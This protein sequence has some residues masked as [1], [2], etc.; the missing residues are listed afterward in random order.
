MRSTLAP[1]LVFSLLSWYDAGKR[2]F[3][4][5]DHPD[6][7]AVLVSEFMLQQT[8]VQAVIPY[9]DRWMSTYPT[10]KDLAAAE[11]DE[12]LLQ[13]EGL[14]YYSRA[15]NLHA[16]AGE[17]IASYGGKVPGTPVDLKKLPGIGEYTAAAVASIA[18]G[19]RAPALDANNLR[20][21]SRLLTSSD[22]KR[23]DKVFAR[24]IPADRPGDFNQA[25][26]DLGS[27]VCTPKNPDCP[28]CPLADWCR[29]YRTGTVSEY[30]QKKARP[31]TTHIEAAI[32]II[33]RDGMVLVQRRA[34]TGLM[35]GL[36]EFPGGKI[37]KAIRGGEGAHGSVGEKAR[38]GETGKR[39]HGEI[40]GVGVSECR[41]IGEKSSKLK[42]ETPEEAVLHEVL[43]ET[44]LT[45]QVC[46]K[47]GVFNHA[48]TRFRVKLHVFICKRKAGT[49]HNPTAKWVTLGELEGLAMPSVNRRIVKRLEER[50]KADF[51]D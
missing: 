23:I 28:V 46:E 48:Y 44:G 18:F 42:A 29:A 16:A 13:W 33:V 7:Y 1:D 31:D 51:V 4:W 17:I 12:V 25:L 50:L 49:V 19:V 26:M 20:V 40:T 32:G 3:P 36:W 8:T 38:R 41:R 39:G 24:V 45:V 2:E 30:P 43:E 22:K 6:P 9:F 21:W 47:L 5:R 34:D 37:R 35:A 11:L 27:S 10:V 15:R 14:G